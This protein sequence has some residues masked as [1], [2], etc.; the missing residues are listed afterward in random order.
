LRFINKSKRSWLRVAIDGTKVVGLV[1]VDFRGG[2]YL[3]R[4]IGF[5]HYLYVL[6]EYR[7][8]GLATKLK[9]AAEQF[10]RGHGCHAVEGVVAKQN[11][12]MI[13][14]NQKL[15][16]EIARYVFSKNLHE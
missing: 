15:G 4:K 1:W 7:H 12:A 11:Q 14:L 16:Y 2:G 8:H 9:K 5:I 13:K 10:C 6:P 3:E